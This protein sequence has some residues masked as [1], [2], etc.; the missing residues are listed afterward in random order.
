MAYV[1]NQ[2]TIKW[3]AMLGEVLGLV[4]VFE[5]MIWLINEGLILL[6]LKL[7]LWIFD[8]AAFSMLCSYVKVIGYGLPPSTTFTIEVGNSPP[9]RFHLY[10]ILKLLGLTM[11]CRWIT[12]PSSEFEQIVYRSK[13]SLYAIIYQIFSCCLPVLM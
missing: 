13:S 9:I 5:E 2:V 3:L 1:R 4:K 6:W 12:C 8:F 7:L 10:L 11:K